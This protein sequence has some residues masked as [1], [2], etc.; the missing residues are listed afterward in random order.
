MA[1]GK[2]LSSRPTRKAPSPFEV[3]KFKSVYEYIGSLLQGYLSAIDLPGPEQLA[4]YTKQAYACSP[5]RADAAPVGDLPD[6]GPIPRKA[7]ARVPSSIA[8]T[9]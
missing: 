5:L 9:L 1:D 3:N 2:G 7:A 6:D 4:D 8:S